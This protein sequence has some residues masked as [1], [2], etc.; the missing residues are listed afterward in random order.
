MSTAIESPT[1]PL[2]LRQRAAASLPIGI[3]LT[4]IAAVW[5]CGAVW[6][7]EE[8]T[9]LADA[10]GFET[11]ELL[12]LT[13]DGMA[14]AMAAVAWAASLD[15]RPA[16]Y[17]R[18]ITA[19]AIGASAASNASAAWRRSAGDQQTVILAAGVA[20]AAMFAFEVL[21]GEVRRQVLR[22]RGQ[23]GPVAITYPRLVR[24]A[25]APWP[26]FAA[27]RKLV[28][29]ATDPARSFDERPPIRAEVV[30]ESDPDIQ[31]CRRLQR[32]TAAAMQSLTPRVARIGLAD[33]MAHW[34]AVAD[35]PHSAGILRP[36]VATPLRPAL[37]AAVEPEP[38]TSTP[39]TVA[40]AA[41]EATTTAAAE[42]TTTAATVPAARSTT[43][44]R[45]V[46]AKT[47]RKPTAKPKRK[48]TAKPTT[49]GTEADRTAAAYATLVADLGRP[50]SG[51]ELAT[52][53]GVS[54]T[55]ANNWKRDH[56]PTTTEES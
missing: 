3:A 2:T 53:A 32:E 42:A 12:P 5:V 51:T 11:P 17:A 48:S 14:V 37:P 28:L 40:P 52:A 19:V 15:A 27:W 6:S 22:R 30:D 45:T 24:L 55:Y 16:V 7:F 36:T 33:A 26:T 39:A 50:P 41:A 35:R 34:S 10:L 20:V 21:L 43:R 54:K 13:L 1:G 8:Q 49:A 44:R 29:V 31:A 38:T 25:L 23:P 4:L 18:L 47:D 9:R 46:V 56:A